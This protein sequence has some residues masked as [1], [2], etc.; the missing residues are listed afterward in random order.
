MQ[1]YLILIYLTIILMR[2]NSCKKCSVIIVL[3]Q[4]TGPILE[5]KGNV[6][7]VRKEHPSM[8]TQA[9]IILQN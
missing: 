5:F 6:R 3:A 2:K 7:Y 8:V 9:D 4:S 1:M